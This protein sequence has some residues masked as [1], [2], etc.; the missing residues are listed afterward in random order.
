[1]WLTRRVVRTCRQPS[2]GCRLAARSAICRLSAAAGSRRA[3]AQFISHGCRRRRHCRRRCRLAR[4]PVCA[5]ATLL[6]LLSQPGLQWMGAGASRLTP[7][8]MSAAKQLVDSTISGNKVHLGG[9]LTHGASRGVTA[10]GAWVHPAT[11]FQVADDKWMIPACG[12]A[13][14]GH[15]QQDV[16]HQ[17]WLRLEGMP[18]GAVRAGCVLRK[19]VTQKCCPARLLACTE[20]KTA[21][22]T[23]CLPCPTSPCSQLL[24]VLRQGWVP[25]SGPAPLWCNGA[26]QC[27]PAA[28]SSCALIPH[29]LPRPF[30]LHT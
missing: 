10:A 18:A 4:P 5:I 9:L 2:A 21:V 23:H 17:P 7:E 24:P 22:L 14:G 1:M 28:A 30:V 20:A 25:A 19:Q 26:Q 8:A 11:K 6:P 15:L 29:A 3:G 16:R 27:V 12:P 13:A